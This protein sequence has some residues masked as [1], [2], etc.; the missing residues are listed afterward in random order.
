MTFAPG[1]FTDQVAIVTGGG[2]GIGRATALALARLGAR[3]VIASRRAEHLEPTAR[4][5]AEVAGAERVHH[6]TCDIR[7]PAEVSALVEAALGRF[8]RIDCLVNNAGGQFPSPAESITPKGWAA[9]IR[10]NL[11]GTFYMT[12]EVAA[13]AMIPQRGGRIVNV[14]AQ[15]FRGFP[16]MAHTGA[17]RAGV[18][19]LTMTLAVEWAQHRICVNAVAPGVIQSSGTVRYPPELL[20]AGRRITPLKR[21]GTEAEVA[22][23]ILFLLSQGFVTGATLYVDGGARLWGEGWPI[24]D[25]VD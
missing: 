23:A 8:G 10:N 4:E 18:E 3:V 13:R 22:D 19:N 5:L 15:I 17:A 1:L 25:R 14:I 16:G 2:T 12:R 9:V 6:Q 11:N 24:P 7:E 20:E 21:L